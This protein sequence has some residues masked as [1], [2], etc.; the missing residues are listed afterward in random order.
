MTEYGQ[1]MSSCSLA[2]CHRNPVSEI[3]QE[4]IRCQAQAEH[5]PPEEL[6][7][8]A[9]GRF[10]SRV[11]IASSFGPEGL[12]VIEIASRVQEEFRV[13]SLDTD[14]LFPE[15]YA[16]MEE[17][18][19]RY[20]LRIERC[21][22][23]VSPEEQAA[24]HGPELWGSNPNLCCQIRKVFPLQAKLK[25][26][27]AWITGIRHEQTVAR[28]QSRKVEWDTRFGI[29]KLNPL[30]D[31][32]TAQVWEFIRANRLPYNPLHDRNYPSIGCTHCTRPVQPGGDPRAGRWPGC[33]KT[34]CGLHADQ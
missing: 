5:C 7:R 29:A 20:G 19:R 34:E 11:A 24:R 2:F 28:S 31:W 3:E 21:R 13:F 4:I 22:P 14:F 12:V 25:E 27:D 33:A 30:A 15:T 18:E 8:W 1:P 10:G 26:L 6:L 17:V 9:F 32:T 16:L 23:S